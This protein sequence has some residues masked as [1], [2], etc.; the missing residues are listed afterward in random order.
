MDFAARATR[1]VSLLLA[2]LGLVLVTAC[3]PTRVSTTPPPAQARLPAPQETPPLGTTLLPPLAPQPAPTAQPRSQVE[4]GEL[5]T[6]PAGEPGTPPGE[7]VVGVPLPGAPPEPGEPPTQTIR[8]G[9]HVAIL[10]PLSGREATVG[11]AL[12]DAA[13]LAVFDFG[14]DNFVLDAYDTETKGAAAAA[15]RAVADGARLILGPLFARAVPEV[16]G[17]AQTR[18]V[19]VV[20]FSNDRTVAAPGVFIMGLPPS[21][22]VARSVAYA[23]AQ[24]VT[25]FAALLPSDALG[26]RIGAALKDTAA[27]LDAEVTRIEYYDPG[28][29]DA[30]NAVKRVAD[31]ERRRAAFISAQPAAAQTRAGRNQSAGDPGFQALVMAD[32]GQRLRTI[33]PLL[34]FYDIDPAQVHIIG[35]PAW[36]DQSLAAEPALVGAWFA[37]PDPAGRAEFERKYR[38]AYARS[39]PRIASLAYDATGLAAVLAR[40]DGGP[41][42]SAAMLSSPSGFAG[43]DGIFRFAPD[44]VVERGLAVLQLDRRAIQVI[45]PAPASFEPAVQ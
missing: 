5:P 37:A 4:T 9:T 41:D 35:T 13:E 23:R 18:N 31:F 26:N 14:D 27:K 3:A 21:E 39:A 24:G 45:S 29:A 12:L 32:G 36:E 44:G 1:W 10:L 40:L 34:P 42:F 38:V 15:Q 7:V 17:V 25:R 20:S 2:G 16:A 43:V 11:R 8:A 28:A 22:A 30:S 6:A 33:A 19:N